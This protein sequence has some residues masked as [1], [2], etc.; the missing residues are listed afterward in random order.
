MATLIEYKCPCCGGKVE[1]D[2]GTQQMK[3]PY[4]ET[5]FDVEAMLEQ[6]AALK[7]TP[8]DELDWQ[9]P[10][11]TWDETAEGIKVYSCQSCGGQIAADETTAATAC[12]YCGNPVVMA[13]NLSGELK[14][15]YVIPFQ[16]DKK[17][18]K[19]ILKRHFTGKKLLPREFQSEAHLEEIKGVYV[20]FWLFDA[21]ADVQAR[22]KAT[23]V[24]T[25]SD[26]NYHYTQ[27][28]YFA[29]ERGGSIGFQRV[30]VDGASK[31]P[32]ELMESLEPYDFS[33]A[34]PFQSAYL[35]GFLADKYD[36]GAEKSQTRANERIRQSAVSAFQNTVSGYH[37]VVPEHSSMRYTASKTTYAMYPVWLLTTRY[38]GQNYLFAINGQTGKIAGDLPMD[39]G[40]YWRWKLLLSGGFAVGFYLLMLL[41]GLF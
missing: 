14:P 9:T 29:V 11:Q 15:D 17:Q 1:F 3:C 37:T 25:W 39:T 10:Q 7:D 13:G 36:Q 28:S 40:A 41:L 31:I 34:V 20:P 22:M 24:R 2:S 21:E 33:Q 5:T 32:D 18:A 12:P 35:A 27:T 30:P 19:E 6:D 26:S 8:Q 16:L 23:R 38:Q 4:C